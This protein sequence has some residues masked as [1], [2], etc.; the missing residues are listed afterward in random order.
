MVIWFSGRVKEGEIIFDECAPINGFVLNEIV[1]PMIIAFSLSS[2]QD[3]TLV[4]LRDEWDIVDIHLFRDAGIPY[5]SIRYGDLDI[6]RKTILF[7]KN[8]LPNSVKNGEELLIVLTFDS[9]NNIIKW[10]IDES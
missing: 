9:N 6:L 5:F 1:K 10:S 7:Y 8:A 2:W 4:A 3:I